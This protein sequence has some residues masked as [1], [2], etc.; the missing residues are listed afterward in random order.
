MTCSDA[1]LERKRA[2]VRR[3]SPMIDL[4][5]LLP[6]L[7]LEPDGYHPALAASGGSNCP[8]SSGM[9]AW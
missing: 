8:M 5:E 9:Y 2:L 4:A 6:H 3:R 7:E 1:A